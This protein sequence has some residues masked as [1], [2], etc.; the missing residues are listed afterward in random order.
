QSYVLLFETAQR[1]GGRRERRRHLGEDRPVLV[2]MVMLEHRRKPS[3]VPGERGA[4]GLVEDDLIRL[5]RRP[6]ALEIPPKAFVGS[7]ERQQVPLGHPVTV[8]ATPSAVRKGGGRFPGAR[9]RSIV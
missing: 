6:Q 8:H 1:L 4:P 7:Q 9:L 3:P 2:L 5:E